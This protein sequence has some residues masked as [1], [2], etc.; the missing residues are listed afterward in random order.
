MPDRRRDR[1]DKGL[2]IIRQNEK[3]LAAG[4]HRLDSEQLSLDKFLDQAVV[5]SGLA[6]ALPEVYPG[7]LRRIAAVNPAASHEVDRLQNNGERQTLHG[8]LELLLRGYLIK[9]GRRYTAA[10]KSF[11]HKRL[12]RDDPRSLPGRTDQSV[13]A[14][15]LPDR[16]HSQIEPAGRDPVCMKCPGRF[17]DRLRIRDIDIRALIRQFKTRPVARNAGGDRRIAQPFRGMIE[18][19]LRI[20]SAE[21]HQLFHIFLFTP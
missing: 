20:G 1:S 6:H 2:R 15:G 21:N 16:A 4:D 13:A 9:T 7:F 10:D 3:K 14:Y 11:L 12:V 17:R 19:S 5:L 8:S 18:R